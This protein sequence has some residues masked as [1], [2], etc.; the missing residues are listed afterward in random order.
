MIAD[1]GFGERRIVHNDAA[2]IRLVEPV[3]ARAGRPSIGTDRIRVGARTGE[4][5]A[6]RRPVG[7]GGVRGCHKAHE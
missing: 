6:D 1:H 3:C 2:A 4:V 7:G 5:Q